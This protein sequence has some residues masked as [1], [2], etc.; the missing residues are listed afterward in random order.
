MPPSKSSKRG[1]PN[2]GP[3]QA[4]TPALDAQTFRDLL[5]FEERLKQ[6]A[7][8]LQSRKKKY[9][10]EQHGGL[11]VCRLKWRQPYSPRSM[12]SALLAVF[13]GFTIFLGYHV[14]IDRKQVRN[15]SIVHRILSSAT[16][17]S[18][19]TSRS[20]PTAPLLHLGSPL[21]L[22]HHLVPFLREWHARGENSCCQ[23]V[24]CAISPSNC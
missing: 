22:S 3:S 13:V 8:R 12:S 20:V 9:E 6:N 10:C 18:N 7:A 17:L 19:F 5:I 14:L 1:N 2:L 21:D 23:Q 24:S 15:I 16:D 11:F 4:F